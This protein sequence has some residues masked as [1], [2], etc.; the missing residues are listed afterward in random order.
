M[1]E[2]VWHVSEGKAEVVCVLL[3][4]R[5]RELQ[6]SVQG[7]VEEDWRQHFTGQLTAG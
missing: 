5:D 6:R 4:G 2:E 3:I 7:R 1:P